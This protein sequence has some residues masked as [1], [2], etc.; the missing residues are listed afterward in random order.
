MEGTGG[1]WR[2]DVMRVF[3]DVTRGHAVRPLALDPRTR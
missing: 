3:L 2:R 1:K